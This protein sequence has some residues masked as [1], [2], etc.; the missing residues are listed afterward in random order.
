MHKIASLTILLMNF[1]KLIFD[2]DL[3]NLD[4]T[5]LLVDLLLKSGLAVLL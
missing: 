1:K 5:E 4:V 2:R 3:F